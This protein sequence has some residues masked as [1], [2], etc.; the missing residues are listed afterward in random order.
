M[1]VPTIR[2]CPLY[3]GSAIYHWDTGPIREDCYAVTQ[4]NSAARRDS[5]N[6]SVV[7]YWTTH[8]NAAIG[9]GELVAV[10]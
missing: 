9:S 4:A 6:M 8:A 10:T 3:A 5:V 2:R 7:I 1:G